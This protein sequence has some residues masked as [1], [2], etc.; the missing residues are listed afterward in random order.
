MANVYS[1]EYQSFLDKLK[2]ARLDAEMSQ[3]DA[4][5]R[6]RRPQSFI[7]RSETGESRVDVVDLTRFAEIYKKPVTYFFPTAPSKSKT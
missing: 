2:K 7:S 5:K 6:L 4:A 3:R 1:K